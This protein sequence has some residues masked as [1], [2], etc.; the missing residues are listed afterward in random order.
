ML[1]N[2]IIFIVLVLICYGC[3]VL[4]EKKWGKAGLFGWI[5]IATIISNILAASVGPMCGFSGVTL[6]NVPFA[7][8]FLAGQMLSEFY[9]EDDG[10]KGVNV[11]L[12]SAISFL[13]IMMLS[14]YLQ[15]EVYDSV[16]A[17]I[18]FLFGFGSYNMCNTVASV[19]MFY[20]ANLVN[21]YIFNRIR[22]KT[23]EKKLWLANN[24]AT[25]LSNCTENFAFVLL[26]LYL[27]PNAVLAMFPTAF[28]PCNL[29]PI[30]A[31]LQIALTTC[32]FEF[33]LSFLSTPTFYL[34]KRIHEKNN[35]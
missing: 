10:K 21:V 12:F 31:C 24:V 11:G 35:M 17:P 25:I 2:S 6:A 7:T 23:G 9:S 20:I 32:V 4:V 27:F 19:L 34:A 33:V 5:A 30:G 15:P 8:I 1:Q 29:M 18:N 28:D 13:G 26:G 14:S 22:E 16:T 3:A